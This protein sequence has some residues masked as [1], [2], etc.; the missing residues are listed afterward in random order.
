MQ[1]SRVGSRTPAAQSSEIAQHAE[2]AAA[3]CRA[4]CRS[5]NSSSSAAGGPAPI[6]RRAMRFGARVVKPNA[7]RSASSASERISRDVVAVAF[8]AHRRS[9]DVHAKG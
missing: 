8:V 4:R 5:P 7:P 3:R 1:P 9:Y 6:A 2:R